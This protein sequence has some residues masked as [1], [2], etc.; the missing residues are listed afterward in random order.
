M[1]LRLLPFGALMAILLPFQN[2]ARM[3]S[4]VDEPSIPGDA[5]SVKN[6]IGVRCDGKSD[7]SAAITAAIARFGSERIAIS[8]DCA[9]VVNQNINFHENTSIY[10]TGRGRIWTQRIGTKVIID[11]EVQSGRY[12]IFSGF[13][14]GDIVFSASSRVLDIFPEWFGAQGGGRGDDQ[15]AMETAFKSMSAATGQRVNLR[16]TYYSVSKCGF[17]ITKDATGLVGQSAVYSVIICRSTAP[18]TNIVTIAG[19]AENRLNDTFVKNVAMV[20]TEEV[21][22]RSG[23]YLAFL[24]NFNGENVVSSNNT[25]QFFFSG[26]GSSQC[27]RCQ[28]MYEFQNTGTVYGFRI[29]GTNWNAS[30]KIRNSNSGALAALNGGTFYGAH[31][32]GAHINDLA[33]E[34]FETANVQYGVYVV[35]SGVEDRDILFSNNIHDTFYRAGFYFE[36]LSVDAGVSIIGGWLAPVGLT[37]PRMELK[38]ATLTH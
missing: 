28:G 33:F 7:D 34:H 13:Q 10:F 32:S 24:V 27:N 3:T 20:S 25:T 4:A 17:E 11:G 37:G 22:G 1:K 35:G 18:N 12:E 21:S 30:L 26:V 31:I 9:L 19:R 29:D 5:L 6:L 14:P 16:G 15:L 38:F 36:N 8:I 2:C 23:L